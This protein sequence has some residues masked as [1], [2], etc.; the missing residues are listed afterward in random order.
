LVKKPGLHSPGPEHSYPGLPTS[1]WK[2]NVQSHNGD[3][4]E[5]MTTKASNIILI[6]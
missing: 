6:F 1:G 2:V 3:I 5:T 4:R